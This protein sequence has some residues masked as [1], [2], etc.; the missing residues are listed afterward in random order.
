M[1]TKWA[2]NKVRYSLLLL[3]GAFRRFWF[4][5]G[6]LWTECPA[7]GDCNQNNNQN[8]PICPGQRGPIPNYDGQT[9]DKDPP[10]QGSA[11]EFC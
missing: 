6:R 1:N 8:I 3:A 11:F 9:M 2:L 10:T 4:L 5:S 7:S